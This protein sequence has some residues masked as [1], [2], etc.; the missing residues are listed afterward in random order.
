[1]V[2]LAKTGR[3]VPQSRAVVV[4]R[5]GKYLKT[6]PAGLNIV[7]PFIDKVLT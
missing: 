4:E 7:V 2:L 1:M 5:F 3:I 6:L